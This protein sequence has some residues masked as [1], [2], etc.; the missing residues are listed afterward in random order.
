M[1][2]ERR[3]SRKRTAFQN[4]ARPYRGT[5]SGRPEG[6]FTRG[7][8]LDYNTLREKP[9]RYPM[10]FGKVLRM[11]RKLVRDQFLTFAEA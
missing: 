10:S 9:S 4:R 6:L 2:A 5:P 8:A 11:Y 1:K 7:V 3:C